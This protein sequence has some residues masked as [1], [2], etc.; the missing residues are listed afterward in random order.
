M[1]LTDTNLVTSALKWS[2]DYLAHNI[3]QGSYT[4]YSSKNKKFLYYDDKKIFK[5]PS[6]HPPT[7]HEDMT[8]QEFLSKVIS[9]KEG[10]PQ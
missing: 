1:V 8:F 3:G 5:V 9:W 10:E 7:T 2:P 6:F 4:V